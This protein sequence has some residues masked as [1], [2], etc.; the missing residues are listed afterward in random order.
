MTDNYLAVVVFATLSLINAAIAQTKN[1]NAA[2]WLL[3]SLF[4]GPV[5][6]ALLVLLPKFEPTPEAAERAKKL[7]RTSR[8]LLIVL[9]VL[10]IGV[11]FYVIV[12]WLV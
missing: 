7:E 2:A 12:V 6:T 11:L 1:R 8:V 9:T 3:L 5:A 4:L 10:M